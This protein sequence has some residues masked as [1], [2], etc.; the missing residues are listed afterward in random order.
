MKYYLIDSSAIIYHF[1]PSEYPRKTSKIDCLIREKQEGKAFLF[2]TNFCIAEVFNAF[3]KY[4]F[5]YTDH[6]N[7]TQKEYE[8]C[9]EEFKDAIHNAKLIYHY[10]LNRYHI[11]NV[12]YIV[13]FEHQYYLIRKRKGEEKQWFLSTFDI[14]FISAG[15]EL[16]RMLGFGNLHL[17]TDEVRIMRICEILGKLSPQTRKDFKIPSYIIYPQAKHISSI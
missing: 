11:L 4:R 9:R 7:I 1:I 3:A 10:E 6:R 2:M 13:P 14:L 8:K 5:R 15:I 12:D 17:I 16:V